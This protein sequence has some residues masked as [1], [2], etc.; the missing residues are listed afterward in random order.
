MLNSTPAK[1]FPWSAAL[2]RKVRL[3]LVEEEPA[4]RP[5]E[6][7]GVRARRTRS[8]WTVDFEVVCQYEVLQLSIC[9]A[10]MPGKATPALPPVVWR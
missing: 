10:G 5:P 8:S 4:G 6:A 7:R 3:L 9:G 2:P 1:P